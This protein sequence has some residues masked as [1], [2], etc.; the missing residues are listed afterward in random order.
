MMK[1]TKPGITLEKYTLAESVMAEVTSI[2]NPE[3]EPTPVI[4]ENDPSAEFK[5][6]FGEVLDFSNK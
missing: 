4:E 6:A 5:S 1:Y 2:I 3:E